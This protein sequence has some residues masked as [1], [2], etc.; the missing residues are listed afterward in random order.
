MWCGVNKLKNYAD[1]INNNRWLFPSMKN[2]T[3]TKNLS[4]RYTCFVKDL[5]CFLL[6]I[7]LVYIY[8]MR[9]KKTKEPK[10]RCTAHTHKV[11]E[12]PPEIIQAEPTLCG[13]TC[14]CFPS[15]SISHKTNQTRARP[16]AYASNNCLFFLVLKMNLLIGGSV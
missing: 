11:H 12:K 10:S 4:L 3:F 2:T 16:S 8:I 15:H 7:L 14:C 6:L 5:I 13:R 1:N 9:I